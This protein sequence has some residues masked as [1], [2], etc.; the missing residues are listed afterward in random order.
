M[1]RGEPE[2]ANINDSLDSTLILLHN[3]YKDRIEIIKE[4]TILPLI[5]CF[6]GRLNQVFMNLLANAIHAIK[7]NGTITIKTEH[8]RSGV[9]DFKKNALLFLFAIPD[10]EFPPI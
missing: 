10:Q 2:L 5:N 4:Y 3:Q 1:D 9:Q 6:A 7:E 8:S